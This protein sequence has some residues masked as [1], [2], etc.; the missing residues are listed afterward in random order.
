MKKAGNSGMYPKEC[1][2]VSQIHPSVFFPSFLFWFICER[3][4]RGNVFRSVIHESF[5]GLDFVSTLW[6]PRDPFLTVSIFSSALIKLSFYPLLSCHR[7]SI[8]WRCFGTATNF[9]FAKCFMQL[10][11]QMLLKG[12]LWFLSSTS[13]LAQQLFY[14]KIS[15]HIEVRKVKMIEELIVLL[16]PFG[17]VDLKA[18]FHR[19]GCAALLLFCSQQAWGSE[20]CVWVACSI[21]EL[22]QGEGMILLWG[23]SILCLGSNLELSF[24]SLYPFS[25][26]LAWDCTHTLSMVLEIVRASRKFSLS[27]KSTAEKAMVKNI[28]GLSF[29]KNT[30]GNLKLLPNDKECEGNVQS[31][32]LPE[33]QYLLFLVKTAEIVS[34]PHNSWSSVVSNSFLDVW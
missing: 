3:G 10:S 12:V 6:S 7:S 14:W 2:K 29:L 27:G 11:F 19:A 24:L 21:S 18:L 9:S 16:L 26:S 30:N 31:N 13:V 34:L 22:P 4:W 32:Y 33:L 28:L 17:C 15:S 1:Q 25:Q 23:G 5:G 8:L 20:L